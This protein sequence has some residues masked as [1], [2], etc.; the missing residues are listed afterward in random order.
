[1]GVFPLCLCLLC[2]PGCR[3]ALHATAHSSLLH[4]IFKLP[5]NIRTDREPLCPEHI[6]VDDAF[7]Q[8]P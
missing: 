8:Q 6:S 2:S 4:Y 3:R 7:H 1:M 5:T